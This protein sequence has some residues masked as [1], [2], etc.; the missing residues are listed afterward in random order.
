MMVNK[1]KTESHMGGVECR[2]P[3]TPSMEKKT[4]DSLNINMDEIKTFLE[5]ILSKILH[6]VLRQIK[7]FQIVDNMDQNLKRAPHLFSFER[8]Y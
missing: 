4:N 2:I 6:Y 3:E 7:N 8:V 5:G 1:T